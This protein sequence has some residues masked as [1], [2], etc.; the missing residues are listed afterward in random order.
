MKKGIIYQIRNIV[1]NKIYVGSTGCADLRFY[2]HFNLLKNGNH[3]SQKLQH[4]YNKHGKKNFKVE[5]LEELP[6]YD[7][8]KIIEREQHY[9]DILKP[10]YNISPYAGALPDN[11]TIPVYGICIKTGEV[12]Y[13]KSMLSARSDGFHHPNIS[14]CCL[15]KWICYNGHYWKHVNDYTPLRW[16][17]KLDYLQPVIRIDRFNKTKIYKDLYAVADEGFDLESV[18]RFCRGS[19]KAGSYK[20]YQWYFYSEQKEYKYIISKNGNRPKKVKSIDSSG[21]EVIYRSQSAAAKEIGG[22]KGFIRECCKGERSEYKGYRW[23]Y[24]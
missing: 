17:E 6:E 9:I 11:E 1:N 7:E 3:H 12:R 4:A 18:T 22:H 20:N 21:N 14:K 5:I 13:Y 16:T 2:K 19:Y 10:F 8:V 15:G 23:E 24:A